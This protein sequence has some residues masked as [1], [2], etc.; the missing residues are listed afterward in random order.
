MGWLI[1]NDRGDKLKDVREGLQNIAGRNFGPNSTVQLA[2]PKILTCVP[3]EFFE[4]TRRRVGVS[5]T[6]STSIGSQPRI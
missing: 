1:I 2:L 4:D 5:E 6:A 3:Q